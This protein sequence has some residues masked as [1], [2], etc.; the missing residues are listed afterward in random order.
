MWESPRL[1]IVPLLAQVIEGESEIVNIRETD[2]RLGSLILLLVLL[3]A[4]AILGT[5]VFWW[6]TRPNQQQG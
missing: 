6:L 3:G 2:D 1:A 5:V 4:A